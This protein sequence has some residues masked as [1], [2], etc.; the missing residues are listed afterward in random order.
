VTRNYVRIESGRRVVPTELGITLI[1]GYQL[2]DGELCKPQ[3]RAGRESALKRV[4]RDP[5]EAG[6]P[7][8][9]DLVLAPTQRR[10]PRAPSPSPKV[11]AHVEAQINLVAQGQARREAVVAHTLEQFK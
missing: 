2:I 5:A 9:L 3:V 8:A 7:A 4:K 6:T 10:P 11:R 1:K